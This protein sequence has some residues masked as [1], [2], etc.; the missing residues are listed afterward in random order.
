[1]S[2][3]WDRGK[4]FEKNVEGC[5]EIG[6]VLISQG[7]KAL[8]LQAFSGCCV[9][10]FCCVARYAPKTAFSGI[11]IGE[12]RKHRPIRRHSSAHRAEKEV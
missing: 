6:M 8:Q 4:I 12:G 10:Q 5:C 11:T 2:D 1:M 9:F 3:K 7:Q